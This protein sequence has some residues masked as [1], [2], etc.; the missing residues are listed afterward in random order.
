MMSKHIRTDLDAGGL[1]DGRAGAHTAVCCRRRLRCPLVP[2]SMGNCV[3]SW[4]PLPN[5]LMSMFHHLL[6]PIPLLL[7]LTFIQQKL[8]QALGGAEKTARRRRWL[9]DAENFTFHWHQKQTEPAD[10]QVGTQSVSRS[11]TRSVVQS[12]IPLRENAPR[13]FGETVKCKS[14]LT[15]HPPRRLVAA[16]FRSNIFWRVLCC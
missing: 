7:T 3:K 5:C 1:A 16:N 11:L 8:P 12:G 9:G 2:Q 10:K 6:A 13:K 15:Q 14:A 4:M